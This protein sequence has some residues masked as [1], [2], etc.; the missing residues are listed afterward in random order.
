MLPN[1]PL[2]LQPIITPWGTWL[3]PAFFCA[4]NFEEFKNVF[5]NLEDQAKVIENCKSISNKSNLK[6]DIAYIQ[7]NLSCTVESIKKHKTSDLS[8]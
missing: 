6:C 1:R 3:E 5:Q 8:L 7:A 2:P 4:I